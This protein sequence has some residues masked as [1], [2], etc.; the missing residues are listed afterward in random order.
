MGLLDPLRTAAAVLPRPQADRPW[1]PGDDGCVG[2]VADRL[3]G[4]DIV[5]AN[6]GMAALE[7]RGPSA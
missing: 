4:L 3:G 1:P 7:Q 2:E 5:V 6:A